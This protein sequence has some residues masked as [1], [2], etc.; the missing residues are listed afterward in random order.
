MECNASE[1]AAPKRCSIVD[2]LRRRWASQSVP[3][4]R[5]V[6]RRKWMALARAAENLAQNR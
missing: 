6:E 1:V 3:A 4:V 2:A 5:Y